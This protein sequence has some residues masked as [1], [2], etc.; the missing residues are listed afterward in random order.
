MS[1]ALQLARKGRYGVKYNPMVGCIIVEKNK[2]IAT[3]YHKIFGQAHAEINALEKIKHS[4]NGATLY[5]TLEPCAHQGKTPPCTQAIIDAGIQQVVIAMVDP[6]PL[7]SGKGVNILEDSGIK[8]K[9]GLLENE[10]M[11]LNRTFIKRMQ[12]GLP[13]VTC[14]IAMSLDGKTSM[15]SGESKWITSESARNDVQKLRSNNQAIMVGSGTILADNPSMTVRIGVDSTPIRVIVDG[16][17]QITDTSLK[18]FS[19]TAK[20]QIFTPENTKINAA[21]KLDLTDILLQLAKQGINSVLL[22]TGPNLIGAMLKATLIDEFII[23][24]AP[25]LMGSDATSMINL[26]ITTMPNKVK[27]AIND[28][29]MVGDDIKITATLK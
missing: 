22:E 4:A 1:L 20:T 23:Y 3:G 11:R 12:T 26:P 25:V 21:G 16:K 10:A 15:A 19:T 2:I 5:I 14:K 6:N 13:F 9:V 28:I 27:L 29:R 7:V 18:I 17:N 8:V 24:T